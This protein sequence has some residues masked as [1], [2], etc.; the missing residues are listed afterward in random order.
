MEDWEGEKAYATYNLF[1]IGP[2]IDNF[3]LT[4]GL[5]NGTAGLYVSELLGMSQNMKALF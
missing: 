2:F 3:R 4:V 1:E 5:Y